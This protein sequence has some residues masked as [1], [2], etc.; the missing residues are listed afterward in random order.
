MRALALALLPLT[1]I[2]ACTDDERRCD[3]GAP[4]TICT[5]AGT[6]EAGYRAS[7][8][9][10]P[11]VDGK[12][13]L[14][15]DARLAPDGTLFIID[16]NN[17]RVRKVTPDGDLAHVAGRGEIPGGTTE[18][19]PEG[20]D[21]NHPTDMLLSRGGN[22]LVLA[23]WHN[24]R[25]RT[26][27]IATGAIRETCGDGRRAYFGDGGPAA[28]AALD[29]PT[30]VAHDPD[31]N[32]VILDQANQVIRMVDGAGVIHRL[33]GQCVVGDEALGGEP[34]ACPN[35]SGKWAYGD[36]AE[37]CGQ[38]CRAGYAAT[39]DLFTMRMAQAEG[40]DAPPGG[41]MVFDDEGRLLFAD[42]ANHLIRRIDFSTGAVEVLAGTEP[43]NGASQPGYAGDGGPATEARLRYPVDLALGADGT[44]YFTDVDNHCVRA[45]DP[46][47]IIRTVAGRCGT[48]GFAGDGGPPSE[49]LLARP[50]GLELA[51]DRLFIAD[52]G[53]HRVRVVNLL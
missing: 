44:I 52:S 53:N 15:L 48:L 10:R 16:W 32:L 31:G 27:D 36:P 45:V 17:H 9:G 38:P 7:D 40:Q 11:A 19:D 20:S 41:K 8:D 50:F 43:R 18:P 14:P 47:G 21:L 12:L 2:A 13:Y 51:G 34:V 46:G 6:G 22:E 5:I 39:G 29:L 28:T 37:V 49:A 33:A 30:A 42:A 25:I 1:A 35:G 24:S 23:A 4:G 3:P 26:I